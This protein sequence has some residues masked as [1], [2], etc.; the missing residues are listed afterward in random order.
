LNDPQV[1][2]FDIDGT[3]T[4]GGDVWRVLI[5]SRRVNPLRKSW[6]YASGWPHYLISKTGLV[7]QAAFRDRWVRLMA[8]LM[9][10]WTADDVQALAG[11]IVAE[12]LIPVLRPDV[13]AVLEQHKAQGTPVV[14]VSTM[15]ERIV[16]GLADHLGVDAGLGSIV[17]MRGEHC[18]GR[19][20][21]E[22][23]S[24]ARKLDFVQRYLDQHHAGTTL[25]DC[26]AYADSASDIAFLAGVGHPAAVYPDAGM[27]AAALES[28][29][30]VI[31]G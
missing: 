4:S 26:A 1:V 31:D 15:F 30:P 21:G 19:I 23:C 11:Q 12:A 2:L 27:R 20:T 3:L 16:G 22:T 6:L 9:T 29:W 28:G 10:G 25:A 13:V 14:L 8:W 24:G 18:T 5:E 7:S 17:A